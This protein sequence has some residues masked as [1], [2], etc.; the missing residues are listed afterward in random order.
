MHDNNSSGNKELLMEILERL[1]KIE[2][3]LDDYHQVQ[4]NSAEAL[5]LTR[6]NTQD[7]NELKD[8]S[9]W[10]GRTAWTALIFPIILEIIL[11]IIH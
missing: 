2:T 3:K 6:Q 8:N 11:S 10:I 1:A 5:N 7:I 4:S 9:K